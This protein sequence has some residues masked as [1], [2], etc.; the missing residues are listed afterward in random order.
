MVRK[1]KLQQVGR[2]NGGIDA[3]SL[4]IIEADD[5]DQ[6]VRLFASIA[7]EFAAPW[8]YNNFSAIQAA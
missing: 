7:D 6:A 3:N 2:F 8:F 1:Y 4:G 5:A